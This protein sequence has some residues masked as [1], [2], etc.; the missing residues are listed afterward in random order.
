MV[1]ENK[2]ILRLSSSETGINSIIIA[3]KAPTIIITLG[4]FK[5]IINPIIKHTINPAKAPSKVLL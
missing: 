3:E 4:R 1:P 5:S 2:G